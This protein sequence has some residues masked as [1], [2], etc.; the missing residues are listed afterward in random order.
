MR[1]LAELRTVIS[2]KAVEHEERERVALQRMG[3]READGEKQMDTEGHTEP[4]TRQ[5]QMPATEACSNVT[6]NS[7]NIADVQNQNLEGPHLSTITLERLHKD[8]IVDDDDMCGNDIGNQLKHKDILSNHEHFNEPAQ[9]IKEQ[10]TVTDNPSDLQTEAIGRNCQ[11]DTKV[12]LKDLMD[13]RSSSDED[14]RSD[15]GDQDVGILDLEQE[16]DSEK[17]RKA[18]EAEDFKQRLHMTL[19]TNFDLTAN[20]AAL[21]A[22][23]GFNRGVGQAE[24]FGDSDSGSDEQ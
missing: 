11:S 2:V 13:V 19:L 5:H 1:L 21:A 8:N 14:E 6:T 17:A 16:F 10:R 12:T 20:T 9:Q 22:K 23:Q 15:S 24:T 3:H 18:K 7:S 4:L